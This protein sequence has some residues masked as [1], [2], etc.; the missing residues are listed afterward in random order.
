MKSFHEDNVEKGLN[1]TDLFGPYD[2][3]NPPSLA[4]PDREA[5]FF[6]GIMYDYPNRRLKNLLGM[7]VLGNIK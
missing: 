6:R 3:T 7:V 4:T 5:I 2:L 1:A